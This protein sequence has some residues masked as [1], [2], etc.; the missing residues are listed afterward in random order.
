MSGVIEEALRKLEPA[1][2]AR[3]VGLDPRRVSFDPILRPE[4]LRSMVVQIAERENASG[5]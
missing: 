4:D 1:L 2:E 5:D 3:L